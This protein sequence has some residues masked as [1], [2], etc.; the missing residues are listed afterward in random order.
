MYN[1]YMDKRSV[2]SKPLLLVLQA[3]FALLIMVSACS[4]APEET[5]VKD[6]IIKHFESRGYRVVKLEITGIENFPLGKRDYMAPKKYTVGV[7]HIELLRIDSSTG[8]HSSPL[9]FKNASVTIRSTDKYGVWMIENIQGI[10][11]T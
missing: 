8:P 5:N 4:V 11:L 10:P 2:F 6:T 1:Y 7:P 9:T 3:F